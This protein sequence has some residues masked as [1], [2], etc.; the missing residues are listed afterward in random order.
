MMTCIPQRQRVCNINAQQIQNSL[1]HGNLTEQCNTF[2]FHRAKEFST[3]ALFHEELRV[4]FLLLFFL[5]TKSSSRNSLSF[6]FFFFLFQSEFP[7]FL[8]LLSTLQSST[9]F[10]FSVRF[11]RRASCI[12]VLR[13]TNVYIRGVGLSVVALSPVNHKGLRQG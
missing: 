2:L 6:F 8:S 12:S 10:T 1:C 3:A 13:T 11:S 7:R 5:L 4:C 9:V